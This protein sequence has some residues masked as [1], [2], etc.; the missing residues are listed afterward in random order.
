[1]VKNLRT[2]AYMMLLL[3]GGAG[4][5]AQPSR[6]DTLSSRYEIM[7]EWF[8]PEKL[9]LHMDRTAYH[10]GETIWFCGYLTNAAQSVATPTSN[11]IYVELSGP[12]GSVHKRVKVRREGDVFPGHLDLQE[13]LDGGRYTIRAYSL[14]QLNFSDDFMFHQSIAVVG[15]KKKKKEP[16][17][18]PDA[19]DIDISFYPEGGRYFTGQM[20]RI[21]FKVMDRQGR[22]VTL[23]GTVKDGSGEVE[24]RVRTRHDGMGMI[25]FIPGKGQEIFLETDDGQRWPLPPPADEGASVSVFKADGKRA[26]R[27][28][29][30]GGGRYSLLLRDMEGIRFISEIDLDQSVKTLMIMEEDLTPGISSLVLTDSGGRIVSLRHIFRFGSRMARAGISIEETEAGPRKPVGVKLCLT[31]GNGKAIDAQCSV[32]VLK[33]SL[34]GHI[35]DDSIE[36]YMLL[37]SELRGSINDPRYY[38]D[39]SVPEKERAAHLDLLMMIQGWSY[40]DMAA[41]ADP[42]KTVGELKHLR[43][44]LQTLRGKVSRPLSSKTPKKFDMLVLIPQLGVSR[45]VRVEEG[46]RFIM[47]SLDFEE[48]TGFMI[49]V[50]RQ[51]SIGDYVPSWLGDSFAPERSYTAAPGYNGTVIA[52]VEVSYQA[53]TDTLEAAVLTAESMHNDLGVN[54]HTL[55]KLDQKAYANTTLIDYLRIKAP[56]FQY[57]NGLMYSL[58]ASGLDGLGLRTSPDAWDE[59]PVQLVVDGAVEPWS[60]FENLTVGETESITISNQPDI[61]FRAKDGVV[62]VRLQYGTSVSHIM[63]NDQSM[64]YFT[65]LGWQSPSDFYAPRYDKGDIVQEDDRRNTIYWNP[66]VKI[67]QGSGELTFSTSDEEEWPYRIIVE[68]IAADGAAF[69]AVADFGEK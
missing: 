42:D 30:A 10:A 37:S 13:D 15:E 43:E 69:S 65:P 59:S 21:G 26:V 49:K 53:A 6:V 35:Q 55:P 17:T 60:G 27:V 11:Y 64:L 46:S 52:P 50:K 67:S 24:Q 54:G 1:M 4:L 16:K 7:T 36:S 38:F 61:L 32:S 58:R 45:L 2:L 66:R 47:D 63:D 9:Y 22:S 14:W 62:A 8:T 34:A 51:E 12:D 39:S 28:T 20:A 23:E 41:V 48:G 33:G 31:D 68:G 29:G 25:Q 56:G 19:E 57:R 44:Y 5:H 18:A 40:Y 3:L